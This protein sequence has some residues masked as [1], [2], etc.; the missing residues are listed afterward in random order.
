MY[1]IV[2]ISGSPLYVTATCSYP[3]LTL[4]RE[5][6]SW[7]KGKCLM[8]LILQR[9][10]PY[11]A[12]QCQSERKRCWTQYNLKFSLS[13]TQTFISE[14]PWNGILPNSNYGIKLWKA[15]L[16]NSREPDRK[17]KHSAVWLHQTT[18][19]LLL[20]LEK[21]QW[22]SVRRLARQACVYEAPKRLSSD[23]LIWPA[24]HWF[25]FW[26]VTVLFPRLCSMRE[27]LHDA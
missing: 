19:F 16:G 13:E 27:C 25:R 26:S 18:R 2:W 21:Q 6:S 10:D 14:I 7:V 4:T 3:A 8:M 17:V 1:S 15:H 11:T 20:S 22:V 23:E 12:R 9:Q 24:S 5:S